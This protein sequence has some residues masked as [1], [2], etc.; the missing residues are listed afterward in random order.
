MN[1][2]Q[3]F[4]EYITNSIKIWVIVQPWQLGIRVRNGKKIKKL[5]KGIYFRIPYFDSVY[6]QENRLRILSMPTQTLTSKDDK[7]ITLNAS[8][9][10]KINNIEKLYD[11]LFQP[12]S[13]IS[14]I[15]MCEISNFIMSNNLNDIDSH[16]IENKVL[17]V[18]QKHDYGLEFTYLKTTNF[19]VVKT[20]RLIQDKTWVHEGLSMDEKH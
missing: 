9:G 14:N 16:K 20:Y 6:I 17:N 3:Q 15:A 2:V 18:L 11:T 1:Q 5:T 8:I 13:T 4:I 7:T 19:A 12:E 10:Y